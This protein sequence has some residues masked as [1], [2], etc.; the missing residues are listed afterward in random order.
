MANS[1]PGISSSTGGTWTL[2]TE[3]LFREIVGENTASRRPWPSARVKSARTARP[4]AVL[5]YLA[6][7]SP[8]AS[9]LTLPSRIEPGTS[10]RD[11]TQPTKRNGTDQDICFNLAFSMAAGDI[12]LVLAN[13]LLATTRLK[14]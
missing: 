5:L 14:R 6:L 9:G 1:I 3:S 2:G 11:A 7:F 12:I 13:I 10:R 8:A 4:S